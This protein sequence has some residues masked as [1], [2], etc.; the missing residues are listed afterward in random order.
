MFHDKGLN[1]AVLIGFVELLLG[2]DFI[3]L[4]R[5]RAFAFQN[6]QVLGIY[7]SQKPVCFVPF[8]SITDGLVNDS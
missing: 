5:L 3:K 2:Q 7:S 1:L 6:G 4:R 8:R